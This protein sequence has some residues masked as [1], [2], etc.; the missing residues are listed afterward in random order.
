MTMVPT[1]T[2]AA[3]KARKGTLLHSYSITE[4]SQI[5]PENPT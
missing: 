1:F 4:D 2:V 3:E 5:T